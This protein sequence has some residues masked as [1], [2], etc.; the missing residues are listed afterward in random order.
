MLVAQPGAAE[1]LRMVAIWL[2]QALFL[3]AVSLSSQNT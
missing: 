1:T 2:K 3:G